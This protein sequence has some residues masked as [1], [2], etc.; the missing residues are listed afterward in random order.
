MD[1]GCVC[2]AARNY[3]WES[4][5]GWLVAWAVCDC[6]LSHFATRWLLP[7]PLLQPLSISKT[8]RQR[9]AVRYTAKA[10]EASCL[11]AGIAPNDN[12]L[13]VPTAGSSADCGRM[14]RPPAH[15]CASGDRA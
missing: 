12:T 7:C 13:H 15:A 2:C 9:M 8:R 3:V 5:D 1:S 14:Q 6:V 4:S 10:T 11:P